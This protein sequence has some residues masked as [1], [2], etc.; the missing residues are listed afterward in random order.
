MVDW[1]VPTASA[2]IRGT[3]LVP[4]SKSIHQRALALAVLSEGVSR[5]ETDG[6]PGEDVVGLA[7]AL[8][9]LVGRDVPPRG[10]V[11]GAFGSEGLGSGRESLALE[12]G[13]NATGFRIAAALTCLRP[14]GARTLLR[15]DRRLLARPHGPLLR[16]IGSLGGHAIRKPSGSVRVIAG[17]IA[18]GEV[19]LAATRSSQ[20]ATALAI[21]ATRWGGISIRLVGDAASI[22]YLDLTIESLRAFGVDASREGN[23]IRVPGAPPR[24]AN[25]VV[26]A[27]ASSAAA[28][29]TA[30]A[31]TGGAAIVPTLHADSRQPD[32]ALLGVLSRMG[33]SVERRPDGTVQ[34][35]GPASGL[36]GAGD[37]D[38]RGSPDLAPLVAALAAGAA[39]E[40]RVVGAPHLR[41]KESDRIASVVS[42][43]R[44][45]GGDAEECED[46]FVVRGVGAGRL[47]GGIV[48]AAGDHRLVLAFGALGLAVPGVSVRGAEAVGKS[49]PAFREAA[50]RAA[51][52]QPV[53]RD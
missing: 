31:L 34:V 44:A 50:G 4:P 52:G 39:G 12:F 3:F 13:R 5:I 19:S 6:D 35:R 42:A 17:G 23:A 25:V 49:Y 53:G 32:T 27:D 29:W 51:R 24:A 37:V 22:G 38:L 46:G 14:S 36:S 41:L 47:T 15:G 9:A 16:A 8:S 43:V 26:E 20:F 40:T 45:I 7:R 21:A 11:E 1:V 18:G 10:S 33:A 30:A 48:D 2:P 28:W